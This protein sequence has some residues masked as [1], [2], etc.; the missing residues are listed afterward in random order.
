MIRLRV[1]DRTEW[2]WI[3]NPKWKRDS[4]GTTV[5]VSCDPYYLILKTR[6]IYLEFDDNN[7]IGTLPFLLKSVLRGTEFTMDEANSDIMYEKDGKTEKIRSL[8]ST[9][10]QGVYRLISELCTLFNCYPIFNSDNYTVAVRALSH[11]G[12]VRE[13][14][15]GKDLSAITKDVNSDDICTRMYV[16]GAY[17]DDGYVGIDDLNNGL[18]YL[19]N[20]DY[21]KEQGLWKPKHE[22]ALTTYKN[23]IE[24]KVFQIKAKVNAVNWHSDRLVTMWGVCDAVIYKL[25]NRAITDTITTGSVLDER[26]P[27]NN[28][29]IITVVGKSGNTWSF[30]KDVPYSGVPST[31]FKYNDQYAIKF[32][33]RGGG[34]LATVESAIL[35][36]QD[37]IA[38]L[39]REIRKLTNNGKST[40]TNK[41]KQAM[42]E[43]QI[44][45]LNKEIAE[46]RTKTDGQYD[47][48]LKACEEAYAM[49]HEMDVLLDLQEEQVEIETNFMKALGPFLRDGEWSD[50]NYILGQEEAML[51][52]AKEILESMSRP[53]V[54][55]TVSR[56]NFC[57]YLSRDVYDFS[58]NTVVRLYDERLNVNAVVYVDK[59]TRYLRREEEYKDKISVTNESLFN[60]KVSLSSVLQ[61]ISSLSSD[62]ESKRSVY[63]RAEIINSNG[64]MYVDRLEGQ[65][66]ILKNRLLS[67]VSNW[68]TDEN[69]N[70][71]FVSSDGLR[72]MKICGE[73]FMIAN[74]KTDDGE[75][76]WRTFGTGEG[77]TADAIITGFLS[78]DRIEA[79][80]IVTS[81]LSA[82]VGKEL[83]ISSNTA[84]NLYVE[85]DG[86]IAAINVTP[87]TASID[88]AHINLNGAVT[89]N[90]YFKINT[91]G[92]MET[93]KGTLGGWEI[94]DKYIRSGEFALTNNQYGKVIIPKPTPPSGGSDDDL[95]DEPQYYMDY[96]VADAVSKLGGN[97]AIRIG[98]S[99]FLTHA[100]EMI[101][102]RLNILGGS[103]NIG[104]YGGAWKSA[105]TVDE[106][107]T[108][109][110]VS[111]ILP[112]GRLGYDTLVSYPDG[113]S[114][115]PVYSFY[116]Q[117]T[118]RYE[119]M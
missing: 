6:N 86:V 97:I 78:G 25:S 3:N 62:L 56:V 7:G 1:G 104:E 72:A 40:S 79:G 16:R 94:G 2:F 65:I 101:A 43:A 74:D 47:L 81:R 36:K 29:D 41:E 100:G 20:F 73:G 33:N 91:D 59:I 10:A 38:N 9:G 8:S 26:I 113:Y 15:I 114:A 17:E 119:A 48:T 54:T 45:E 112:G 35:A 21:Y 12:P 107:G 22:Q 83:D 66:D 28:G 105:F 115:I 42:Y 70:I 75:W 71:M 99:F 51:A 96:T 95:V 61:R 31:F 14:A 92:S 49:D 88:A 27:L 103:I 64:T 4:N 32:I 24:A 87:E 98:D 34:Q 23:Q 63:N 106:T 18:G 116:Q 67:A 118:R 60:G 46:L 110:A 5:Q 111:L 80:S 77:F 50:N 30:S 55:Y 89:A 108:V 102:T 37:A 39:E 53:K 44:A 85:K 82:D 76:D 11:K 109:S 93:I 117:S 69:G 84:L 13:M 90:N 57:N 68:Y 19:M 52:D 58:I